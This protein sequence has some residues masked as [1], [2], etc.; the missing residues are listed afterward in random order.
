MLEF[1][2][3]RR[4]ALERAR[5]TC[6]FPPRTRTA[7]HTA[8]RLLPSPQQHC[9]QHYDRFRSSRL[10]IDP[11]FYSP[12][13]SGVN[14][15]TS[16]KNPLSLSKNKPHSTG[17]GLPLAKQKTSTDGICTAPSPRRHPNRRRGMCMSVRVVLWVHIWGWVCS[18]QSLDEGGL[19]R[20]I[21][22]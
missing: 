8:R 16:S 6:L 12:C 7:C 18:R 5:A 2:L 13:D 11:P 1:N 9:A 17:R 20:N 15:G 19:W 4:Y 22:F 10:Y 14:L 21:I 3:R